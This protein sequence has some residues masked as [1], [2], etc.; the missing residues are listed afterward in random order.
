[1]QNRDITTY[2]VR[3]R[4]VNTRM[5]RK[6]I[7][8]KENPNMFSFLSRD[9]AKRYR[10]FVEELKER[11]PHL[12][13][14]SAVLRRG[15]HEANPIL[16]EEMITDPLRSSP[17]VQKEVQK[18]FSGLKDV[19]PYSSAGVPSPCDGPEVIHLRHG[20]EGHQGTWPTDC[21]QCGR[22]IGDKLREL[23]VGVAGMS[24]TSKFMSVCPTQILFSVS[25][26]L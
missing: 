18:G 17:L 9:K 16:K 22:N 25:I 3:S 6:R 14:W 10:V 15:W 8:I 13:F 5:K 4:I 7:A 19:Y 23:G 26:I 24:A 21:R 1:M 20:G 12:H 11:V 2:T